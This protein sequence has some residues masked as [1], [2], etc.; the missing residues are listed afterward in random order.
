MAVATPFE[1]FTGKLKLDS[2]TQLPQVQAIMTEG[3]KGAAPIVADLLKQREQLINLEL[4]NNPTGKPPVLAAY[5]ATATKMAQAEAEAFAKVY[6][7]LKPNQLERATEAF[8]RMAGFFQPVASAG[9]AGRGPTG[10]V[11]GRMEIFV[12]LFKLE[13]EQKKDVKGWFDT[14]HKSL[15]DTR[16]GL[17]S[18]RAALAAAIEAGKPAAEI[19]AAANA[20]AIHVTTM[21]DAEMTALARLIQRL[22]P[23]QRDNRAAIASAFG[24]M[25]GIFVNSGKWDIIPDGRGY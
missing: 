10:A 1:D 24:L 22:E 25:R 4:A 7:L 12:T 11:L 19:E 17:T 13:G 20:Y 23:A 14:A 5:V 6:A 9:R 8:D 21:T 15:A 3:A 16:K 2:K 18:S